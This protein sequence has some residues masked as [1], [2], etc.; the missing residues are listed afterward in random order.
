MIDRKRDYF[1]Q[2]ADH[3]DESQPANRGEMLRQFVRQFADDLKAVE[4]ILEIGTGT[5]ALIPT[6][7]EVAP[8]ARLV[9]IDLAQRMLMRARRRV[10]AAQLVQADVHRLPFASCLDRVICH[11]SFPHFADPLAA[12]SDIGRVLRP[13]G[14]LLIA[15][16]A[17]R[18]RINAIHAGAD[19]IIQHDRLPTA[20]EMRRMLVESGYGRVS[21]SDEPQ[22]YVARGQRV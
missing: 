3:W 2:L 14:W 21:V 1:E 17:G 19:S 15:H 16:N 11:N 5:G 6:L 8:A 20:D 9:S 13:G 10:P 4:M 7:V 18:E 22:Q 12:L